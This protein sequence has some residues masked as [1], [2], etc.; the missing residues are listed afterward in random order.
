[1]TED[2]AP[3]LFTEIDFRT[4]CETTPFSSGNT[5]CCKPFA[6]PCDSDE[7]CCS[8]NCNNR[9]TRCDDAIVPYPSPDQDRAPKRDTD[10]IETSADDTAGENPAMASE[11]SRSGKHD[12]YGGAQ[13]NEVGS[14][15]DRQYDEWGP[16]DDVTPYNELA[17]NDDGL[18]DFMIGDTG[19]GP[20][21]GAGPLVEEN[22]LEDLDPARTSQGPADASD[23]GYVGTPGKHPENEGANPKAPPPT[24][25]DEGS[26]TVG[27][28]S[29]GDGEGNGDADGYDSGNLAESRTNATAT[30]EADY[31]SGIIRTVASS[32]A[33]VEAV[34]M[35]SQGN[36][37]YALVTGNGKGDTIRKA[38][39]PPAYGASRSDGDVGQ[40]LDTITYTGTGVILAIAVDA[41]DNLIFTMED[42]PT[43][44]GGIF[45]LGMAPGG[46]VA[47]QQ[48]SRGKSHDPD[49]AGDR[50]SQPTTPASEYSPAV[51]LAV[52][53]GPFLPGV[54]VCP[55][56]GDIYVTRGHTGVARL[57][58]GVDGDFSTK[59]MWSMEDMT[60]KDGGKSRAP[61]MVWDI[62][63]N[64]LGIVYFTTY[65][66][67]VVLKGIFPRRGGTAKVRL[68]AGKWDSGVTPSSGDGGRAL[69]A[70]LSYPKGIAIDSEDSV[71]V[72]EFQGGRIRKIS[73]EDIISTCAGTGSAVSWD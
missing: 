25:Y 44:S 26:A 30:C 24:P 55:V 60:F 53:L 21:P 3:G 68:E 58:K 15:D 31:S 73:D 23:E 43:V 71:Y 38:A 45:F 40:D 64:S 28:G 56:T 48:Q 35:D 62:A 1:M 39:S 5:I 29:D 18:Y 11:D 9:Y 65:V 49:G 70:V 4:R 50:L 72:A 6:T 22:P 42:A 14:N 61:L 33:R 20:T 67:G 2:C 17:Q 51:A 63:V 41:D 7:A 8:G 46:K 69:W 57:V 19:E 12:Q 32:N 47:S 16:D 37:F 13:Y 66:Q 52:D 10:S 59:V 34:A 36:V 27:G 54:A